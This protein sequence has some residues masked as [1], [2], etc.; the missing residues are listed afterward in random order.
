MTTV[1][2]VHFVLTGLIEMT[3]YSA[4]VL[5]TVI[6][7]RY[8]EDVVQGDTWN[9]ATGYDEVFHCYIDRY[10]YLIMSEKKTTTQKEKKK[11]QNATLSRSSPGSAAGSASTLRSFDWQSGHQEKENVGQCHEDWDEQWLTGRPV[12]ALS[13]PQE[14]PLDLFFGRLENL[15]KKNRQSKSGTKV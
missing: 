15:W 12:P 7:K 9:V 4:P 14:W 1:L 6:W 5:C 11:E 10:I 8:P 13:L 3:W 2:V